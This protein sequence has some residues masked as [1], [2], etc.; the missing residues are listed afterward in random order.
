MGHC[1]DF[2]RIQTSASLGR[3]RVEDGLEESLP[4]ARRPSVDSRYHGGHPLAAALDL[5]AGGL[6]VV[7]VLAEGGDGG[8]LGG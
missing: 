5:A 8:G 2:Q 3:C 6:V 7:E 1:G 4:N